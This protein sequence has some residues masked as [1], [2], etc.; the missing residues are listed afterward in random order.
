M[1]CL[2]EG[3][4]NKTSVYGIPALNIVMIIVSVTLLSNFIKVPSWLLV[5]PVAFVLFK[6]F[7]LNT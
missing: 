6:F 3:P 2:A 4:F 5:I 7:C 1:S